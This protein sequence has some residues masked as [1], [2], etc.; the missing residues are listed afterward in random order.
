M[1]FEKDALLQTGKPN[2]TKGQYAGQH[3]HIFFGYLVL[4]SP[5]P[6]NFAVVAAPIPERR[7]YSD[8]E[9]LRKIAIIGPDRGP[10]EQHFPRPVPDNRGIPVQAYG[11]LKF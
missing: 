4:S 9:G 11:D 8:S 7:R 2:Q 1:N 3:T 6:P 10:N 5:E